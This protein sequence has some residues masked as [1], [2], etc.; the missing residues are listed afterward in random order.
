MHAVDF[1]G[2]LALVDGK[3][4]ADD[5]ELAARLVCRYGKGRAAARVQFHPRALGAGQVLEAHLHALAPAHQ[6]GVARQR[7]G[8]GVQVGRVAAVGPPGQKEEPRE[9]KQKHPG[10]RGAV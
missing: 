10:R 4:D 8:V 1:E 5:L 7:V 6:I 2:P 9:K 3:A